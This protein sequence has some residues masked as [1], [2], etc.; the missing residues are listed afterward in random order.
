MPSKTYTKVKMV[1]SG[2]FGKVW[3][4]RSSYSSEPLIMK[5]VTLRGLP[6]D[7]KEATLNEVAVLKK[8]H[9]PHIIAYKDAFCSGSN[10]NICMEFAAGGDMAAL[11]SHHRRVRSRIVEA[12][13]VKYLWQ[14]TSAL[15]YCH[16]A[17]LL[18]RDLKPANV[19]LDQHANVKLGDFGVSRILP[20]TFAKA[21]TQCGTPLYMS[22]EM[23]A[24][25]AYTSAADVWALGCVIYELTTL[26]APW[27]EHLGRHGPAGGLKGLMRVITTGAINLTAMHGK[28]SDSLR[29]VVAALLARDAT[30]R[31]FLSHLLQW[32]LLAAAAPPGCARRPSDV[33]SAAVDPA[34]ADV[35]QA[36][37]CDTRGM[38]RQFIVAPAGLP[39]T[40]LPPPDARPY[41]AAEETDV[42]G[43]ATIRA[44]PAE[45]PLQ[46]NVDAP[47]AMDAMLEKTVRVVPQ[48]PSDARAPDAAPARR[49]EAA[50][51]L[52]L[53]FRRSLARRRQ[54]AADAAA[55]APPAL[56]L[57]PP[58]R[59]Q[60]ARPPS[61]A[62]R[63]AEV[64]EREMLNAR[65][66]ARAAAAAARVA[67]LAANPSSPAGRGERRCV[68]DAPSPRRAPQR[69][70]RHLRPTEQRPA[71]EAAA[72]RIQQQA[73]ASLGRRRAR[74]LMRE[75]WEAADRARE[76][77]RQRCIE[78][79][80]AAAARAALRVA[81]AH[82]Q[83]VP[84]SPTPAAKPAGLKPSSRCLA[85]GPRQLKP[86]PAQPASRNHEPAAVA[87]IQKQMRLS[88]NRRRY[89]R[90][91]RV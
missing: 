36:R 13:C 51:K 21:M 64:R 45:L 90:N 50:N 79:G 27:S 2:T 53:S 24:G 32:P 73:K 65:A 17:R 48:L 69:E 67:A 22:P 71:M 9:H 91:A 39:S 89:V 42:D 46:M 54:R 5:E 83:P 29:A 44:R 59:Q 84:A 20:G 81:R 57:P 86:S 25:K 55:A 88:L 12:D 31:P 19:F 85:T 1:G 4:V 7:E 38:R 23:C 61:A 30:R 47:A 78:E 26:T 77:E 87:A 37:A 11:I 49:Q 34:A 33:A 16:A 8:L 35:E 68:P 74:E 56:A 14:L 76:A 62:A 41:A 66:A 70:P 43:A 6:A 52:V 60:A 15:A 10:L 28:Y 80:R 82:K 63:R 58:A 3:L 40:P 75:R 72:S 18:H